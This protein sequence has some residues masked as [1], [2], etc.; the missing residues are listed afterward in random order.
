MFPQGVAATERRLT[1]KVRP[2]HAMD[3]RFVIILVQVTE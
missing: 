2:G 1:Q 3:A